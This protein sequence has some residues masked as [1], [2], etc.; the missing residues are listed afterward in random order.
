MNVKN[1]L[2]FH[3]RLFK[4]LCISL[5]VLFLIASCSYKSSLGHL[6]SAYISTNVKSVD[7]EQLQKEQSIV[8]TI[9]VKVHL[10]DGSMIFFEKG[11]KV[12][13]DTLTGSGLKYDINRSYISSV[14]QV[15]IDIIVYVQYY[16]EDAQKPQSLALITSAILISIGIF[17]A[18][19]YSTLG[20]MH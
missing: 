3:A 18:I 8:N 14:K 5:F 16:E 20:A 12:S 19:G 10:P 11:F 15:P 4:N 6:H 7:S 13:N 2:F 1:M 9:P 17:L